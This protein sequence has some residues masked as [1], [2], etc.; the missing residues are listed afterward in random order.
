MKSVTAM[1]EAAIAPVLAGE[2]ILSFQEVIRRVPV[3]DHVFDYAKRIVRA[4]RNGQP[5]SMEDV[6]HW[7]VWGAGPR[8]SINLIAA[9]RARAVIRG[10]VHVSTEDVAGVARPVLRHRMGLN[11]SAQ[12]EGDWVPPC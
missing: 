6:T 10:E 5:D 8:A 11:F 9:A 3:A 12:A 4:T 1:R 2:Q 7:T